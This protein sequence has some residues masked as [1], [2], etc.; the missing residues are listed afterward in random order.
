MN[1]I[2]VLAV[3]LT[4]L[5]SQSRA[6]AAPLFGEWGSAFPGGTKAIEVNG[7]VVTPIRFSEDYFYGGNV[8]AH[9]YFAHE[10]SIGAELEGYYV[11]QVRDDTVLAGARRPLRWRLPAPDR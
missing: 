11:D 4:C 3:A 9:Y 5:A 10:L 8:A 1:R 7:A 6:V 2:A